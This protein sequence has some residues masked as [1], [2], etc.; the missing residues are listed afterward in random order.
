[1]EERDGQLQA[2]CPTGVD[3]AICATTCAH[4][5]MKTE[6][7]SSRKHLYAGW[8]KVPRKRRFLAVDT[9]PVPRR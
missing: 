5:F 7:Q 8:M 9:G 6:V 1:M 2:G 4:Y 3:I